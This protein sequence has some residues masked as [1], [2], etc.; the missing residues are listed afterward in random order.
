MSMASST[1]TSALPAASFTTSALAPSYTLIEN[2]EG[3]KGVS[4]HSSGGRGGGAGEGGR[5]GWG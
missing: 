2:L 4:G 3:I 5:G 1:A